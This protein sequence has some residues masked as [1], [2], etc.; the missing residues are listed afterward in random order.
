MASLRGQAVFKKANE[1]ERAAM[2]SLTRMEGV[3][4]RGA[5]RD[6]FPQHH[7]LWLLSSGETRPG[8]SAPSGNYDGNTNWF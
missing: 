8:D 1:L 5:A 2:V 3:L 4:L 7:K 6:S